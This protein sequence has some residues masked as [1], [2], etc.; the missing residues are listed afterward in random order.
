MTIF[1][2]VQLIPVDLRFML[3]SVIAVAIGCANKPLVR[4]LWRNEARVARLSTGRLTTIAALA[5][6]GETP[7]RPGRTVRTI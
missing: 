5:G 2:A 1:K 3:K 7:H 4:T 6:R